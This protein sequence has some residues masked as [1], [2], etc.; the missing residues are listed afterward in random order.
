M[1]FQK[2]IYIIIDYN[3]ENRLEKNTFFSALTICMRSGIVA[4]Y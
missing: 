4:K 1:G 2:N 3:N